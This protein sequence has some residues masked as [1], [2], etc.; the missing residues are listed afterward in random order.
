MIRGCFLVLAAALLALSAA[1]FPSANAQSAP[2]EIVIG[3][4]LPLTGE[5]SRIGTYFKAGYEL[6]ATARTTEVGPSSIGALAVS[7]STMTST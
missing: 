2:N 1:P 7:T 4:A 5:E 6:A 3:A